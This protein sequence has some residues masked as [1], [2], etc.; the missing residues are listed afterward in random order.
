MNLASCNHCAQNV[1]DTFTG[2]TITRVRGSNVHP[3]QSMRA[4]QRVQAS[5]HYFS[6]GSYTQ[7]LCD[8]LCSHSPQQTCQHGISDPRSL[9]V[10]LLIGKVMR[11][12]V[13]LTAHSKLQSLRETGKFENSVKSSGSSSWTMVVLLAAD[14]LLHHGH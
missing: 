7:V 3:L 1:H 13:K 11:D 10:V 12:E 8:V 4:T 14:S 5:S 9:V 6:T 2:S